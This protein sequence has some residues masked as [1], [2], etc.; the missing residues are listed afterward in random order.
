MRFE[1]QI[2]TKKPPA[3]ALRLIADFRHLKSWD[4]SVLEVEP[5]DDVFGQGSKYR[6]LVK[7]GG[8]PIEME[9]TVTAYEPG[10]RAV[11]TGIAPK[12]TAI[13]IIEVSEADTGTRIDY[14]AEIKMAFPY[15]LLDPLLAMGFKKTVDHAVAG[16]GRFLSA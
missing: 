6:V 13:D 11:L 14:T 12:A 5:L 4:D 16:L 10:V 2:H 15:A 7:F 9:Y 8:N 1:R 3:E